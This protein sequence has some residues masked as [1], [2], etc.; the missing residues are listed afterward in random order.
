MSTNETEAIQQIEQLRSIL[1]DVINLNVNLSSAQIYAIRWAIKRTGS[2]EKLIGVC[3]IVASM[4]TVVNLA[5]EVVAEL[6]E[7][8]Q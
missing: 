3:E 5:A 2:M 6:K 8:I 1:V 4:R 7:S